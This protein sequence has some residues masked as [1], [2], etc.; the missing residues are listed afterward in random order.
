[1]QA[2]KGVAP[3][4][5][6]LGTRWSLVVN[7]MPFYPWERALIPTTKGWV[8]PKSSL[9]I[10]DK[11]KKKHLPLPGFETQIVQPIA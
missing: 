4:I 10:V 3:F 8:N 7:C 1:M 6:N 11:R 9:P 2:Y 5:L